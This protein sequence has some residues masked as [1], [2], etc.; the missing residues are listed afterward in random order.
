MRMKCVARIWRQ[1]ASQ[2]EE[3]SWRTGAEALGVLGVTR[4]V[5]SAGHPVRSGGRFF[6]S[7]PDFSSVVT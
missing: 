2:V 4:G 6:G 5:G 7:I 1:A 3:L